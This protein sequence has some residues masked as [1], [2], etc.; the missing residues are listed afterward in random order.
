M[1]NEA[2]LN[3]ITQQ[4]ASPRPVPMAARSKDT[5]L[6][7]MW[8][9]IPPGVGGGHGRLSVVSA[10]CCQVEVSATRWSLVQRSPTDCD[11]SLCVI[12]KPREWGGHG[13]PGGL[14]R[15]KKIKTYT[16]VSATVRLCVGIHSYKITSAWVMNNIYN[17]NACVTCVNFSWTQL[18]LLWQ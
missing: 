10:V 7:R 9:R 2:L 13:P 15:Q 18:P 17:N 12:K 6:L 14:S 3:I 16:T 11:A 8:V 4:Y 5:R 1:S